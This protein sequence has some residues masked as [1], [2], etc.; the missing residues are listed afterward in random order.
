MAAELLGAKLLAPFFG[1]SLYVWSSVMAVTLIGLALGYFLGGFISVKPKLEKRLYSIMVIGAVIIALM[2]FTVQM[3]FAL[4]SNLNLLPSVLISSVFLLVPPVFLMGMVSPLIISLIDIN[5]KSP[6]KSSGTVYAVSTVGGIIA[7]F[8]FGFYIIPNF[9]LSIPCIVT[10]I[11][12]GIVPCTML[13]LKKNLLPLLLVGGIWFSFR[14]MHLNKSNSRVK[15]VSL[16]EGILGQLLVV[17][18]P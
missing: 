13:L 18:Y 12:L 16:Q 3:C 11:F 4:F 8:L 2:P 9:G 6:G 14:A 7:T 10:A 15:I 17:D 1:S 5:F